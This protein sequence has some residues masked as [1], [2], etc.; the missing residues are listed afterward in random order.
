MATFMPLIM[1]DFSRSAGADIRC[2]S[3]RS[4][5]ERCAHR[6]SSRIPGSGENT[7][8]RIETAIP[9]QPIA[10]PPRTPIEP[11]TAAAS[12]APD[13]IGDPV[14][15]DLEGRVDPAEDPVRDHALDERQLGDAFDRLQAVADQLR[16]E[17]HQRRERD[18]PAG[19]RRQDADDR[20]ADRRP[21]Q[22][23]PEAQPA[24]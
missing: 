16:D 1:A 9:A 15:E 19:Q 7:S 17:H 8:S 20:R 23:R 5:L 22:R 24:R 12:R 10:I 11:A 2:G 18:R 14:R 3:L 4:A 6:R 21:D 13:R